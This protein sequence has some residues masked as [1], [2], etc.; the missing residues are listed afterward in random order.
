MT[1]VMVSAQHSTAGFDSD[2]FSI[3]VFTISTPSHRYDLS[4]S[5]LYVK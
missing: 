2:G 5:V 4:R 3:V 1:N